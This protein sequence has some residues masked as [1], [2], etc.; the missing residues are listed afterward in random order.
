MTILKADSTETQVCQ[1]R[2][3]LQDL[4]FSTSGLQVRSREILPTRQADVNFQAWMHNGGLMGSV[5][6]CLQAW[7][8]LERTN[9]E[10]PIADGG[11]YPVTRT[12]ISK[13][14]QRLETTREI[15][16]SRRKQVETML[17]EAEQIGDAESIHKLRQCQNEL[18][19]IQQVYENQ[20]VSFLKHL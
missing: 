13:S 16:D 8:E 5:C 6:L 1:N 15:A 3:T 10:N 19:H 14:I 20:L 11:N 18:G 12:A 4:E 7:V 17:M 9:S 2:K